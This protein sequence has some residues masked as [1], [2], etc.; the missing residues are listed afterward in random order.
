MSLIECVDLEISFIGIHLFSECPKFL[1]FQG[2]AFL[3]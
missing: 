1:F 2:N 3:T